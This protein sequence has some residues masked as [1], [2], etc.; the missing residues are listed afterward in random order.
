M[1]DILVHMLEFMIQFLK[2]QQLWPV[3]TLVSG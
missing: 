1:N 3:V 2:L